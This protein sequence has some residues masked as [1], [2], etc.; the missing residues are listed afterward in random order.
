MFTASQSFFRMQYVEMCL[1]K[2]GQLG[3]TEQTFYRWRTELNIWKSCKPEAQTR[4]SLHK[5]ESLQA[6]VSPV[7]LSNTD[8][9]SGINRCGNTLIHRWGLIEII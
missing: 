6:R 1:L 3:V 9:H 5:V 4:E 2:T 7:A 8:Q